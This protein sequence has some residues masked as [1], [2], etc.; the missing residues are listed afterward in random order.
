VVALL[1]E[2]QYTLH[3]NK[4]GPAG[5]QPCRCYSIISSDK[6][7]DAKGKEDFRLPLLKRP[8]AE[9]DPQSNRGYY[10][11]RERIRPRWNAP[12]SSTRS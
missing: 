12:A 7:H 1:Q 2:L 11:G 3:F 6:H 8:N 4:A 5:Y 9:V 10:V